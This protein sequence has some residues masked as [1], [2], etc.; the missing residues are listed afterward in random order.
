MGSPPDIYAMLMNAVP[1]ILKSISEL[2][3]QGRSSPAPSSS[4]S[5]ETEQNQSSQD[6]RSLTGV[7][8]AFKPFI[9]GFIPPDILPNFVPVSR[10]GDGLTASVKSSS[11]G[12]SSHG[13]EVYKEIVKVAHSIGARPSDLLCV[14]VSESGMNPAVPNHRDGDKSKSIQARGLNQFTLATA[15]STGMTRD[16]WENEYSNLSALEQ[17][18]WIQKFLK[19]I[20]HSGRYEN[21]GQLKVANFAPGLVRKAGDPNT[22]LYAQFDSDGKVSDRW[23]QNK[24]LNPDGSIT[25][26]NVMDKM[27]KIC[28]SG[29]YKSQLARMSDAVGPDVATNYGPKEDFVPTINSVGANAS[30]STK[31]AVAIMAYGNINSPDPVDPIDFSGRNIV[32]SSEERLIKARAQ[33]EELTNQIKIANKIPSL[34]MLINPS[35][36]TRSYEHQ[37]DSPKGR[38]GQIVHMWLEKPLSISSKG[39]TA[40]QYVFG[41]TPDNANANKNYPRQ[42]GGITNINRL[43]SL[44]YVNLMSLVMMYRNNGHLYT[45]I[46][47]QDQNFGIPVISMSIFIYYDGHIYIGS[48]DDFSVDD[49]ADKPY[50]LSY[51]WKFTARYDFEVPGINDQTIS[52]YGN[53]QYTSTAFPDEMTISIAQD[54]E[55]RRKSTKDLLGSL[56]F[57]SR[58]S[59]KLLDEL[60]FVPS[61]EPGPIPTGFPVFPFDEAPTGVDPVGDFPSGPNVGDGTAVG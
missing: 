24:Q 45:Q 56:G 15:L 43:H 16:Y 32:V 1:D 22:V 19:N 42:G 35:E 5:I 29:S 39:V 11:T 20:N 13:P 48:F 60:G 38:R 31:V 4:S 7:R 61:P 46:S 25:V 10:I 33:S 26:K 55:T 58:K 17:L 12:G 2:Y 57:K 47:D 6:Y 44:S 54:N 36:F 49:S 8:P 14:F 28:S 59:D 53:L 27:D 51:N 3:I 9:M 18:P 52:S 23:E 30:A 40:A 37:I 34:L 41:P 21:A 50:N